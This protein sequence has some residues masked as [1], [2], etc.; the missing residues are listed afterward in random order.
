[1]S[2]LA[3]IPYNSPYINEPMRFLRMSRTTLAESKVKIFWIQYFPQKSLLFC[4]SISWY[5]TARH[6]VLE[7]HAP[8]IWVRYANWMIFCYIVCVVPPPSFFVTT[9]CLRT[10]IFHSK[11]LSSSR[12]WQLPGAFSVLST[13]LDLFWSSPSLSLR[14]FKHQS[15]RC[16]KE[17]QFDQTAC[18]M[19]DGRIR[20]PESMDASF[21][22][23]ATLF[24]G[25]LD[26]Q[27]ARLW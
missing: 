23:P 5:S 15:L 1:M 27:R 4:W 3:I 12:W 10:T 8:E 6:L 16:P 19:V 20:N 13:I 26:L 18:P 17:V 22:K 2:S 14:C 25:R 21:R 11:G 7:V 24:N 9:S